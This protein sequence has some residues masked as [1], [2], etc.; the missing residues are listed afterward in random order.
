[1]AS[2]AN[3]SREERIGLGIAAAAHVALVAALVWQVKGAPVKLPAPER[4]TVSLAS[5]V[6]L[7]ATAPRPA[8]DAQAAIAPVLAPRSAPDPAPQPI[9]TV[10][11]RDEPRPVVPLVRP[12]PAPVPSHARVARAVAK[13][14]PPAPPK[15]AMATKAGGGSRLGSDFLAGV[16]AGERSQS[17]GTPAAAFGPA[18]SASLQQA[19]A[20]Q[21]KPHWVLPQGPDV[22]KLVTIVR[23]RLN[24]DGS[25]AGEPQVVSQSGVTPTNEAQKARHGEQAIRAVRLAAPFQ[26]PAQFYDKWKL[27]NSRFDYRLSL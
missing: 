26:L 22:E 1:M 25:L 19:I 16:G 2:L 24:P 6:S 14:A 7:T 27:V 21:L 20:R 11:V 9:P 5:D 8:A 4:I 17:A 13:A 15:A 3:L 23:F 10:T 12:V 18:E